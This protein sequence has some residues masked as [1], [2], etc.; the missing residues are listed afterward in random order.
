MIAFFMISFK[1][2]K[3]IISFLSEYLSIE[4]EYILVMNHND[5]D[6][7]QS[8]YNDIIITFSPFNG[9]HRVGAGPCDADVSNKLHCFY[10]N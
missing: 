4:I 7:V 5:L 8:V 10:G 2:I 3:E 9:T 6:S 1:L